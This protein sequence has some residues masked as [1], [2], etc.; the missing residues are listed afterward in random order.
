MQTLI[1]RLADVLKHDIKLN[2]KDFKL[3]TNTII[4]TDALTASSLLETL[5][6][7]MSRELNRIRYTELSSV[8]VFLKRE[9]RPLNRA[10]GV[11]IPQ[12]TVFHS[13]G[14]LNNKAIFPR[15]NE[16]ML[17]YTLICRKKLTQDEI[18][19]DL[20]QLLP[21]ITKEDIDHTENN[22]WDKA[23]PLYDLQRYLAVKKLH[24]IA[25]K[26]TNLAIFGNYVAGISLR[27][28][29]SAAKAFAKDPMNYPETT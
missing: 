25:N 3:K 7:E 18:L 27:E 8:T 5:R 19:S 15:N 26:E 24:Q 12:G 22:Y 20:K 2:S 6:P 16:N 9:L 1:N 10:F 29:I 14:I 21:E 17:S 28:M 13:F 4:C 23:L 11:L